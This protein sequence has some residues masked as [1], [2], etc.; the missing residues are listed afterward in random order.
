MKTGYACEN[1]DDFTERSTDIFQCLWCLKEICENCY[2]S[3][4]T[5]KE[6]AATRTD[7][8]LEARFN[9]DADL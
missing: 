3:W 1:C 8:E 2:Y 9:K 4:K 5:C 6:C 7:A